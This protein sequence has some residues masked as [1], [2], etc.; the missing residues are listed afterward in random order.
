MEAAR[1]LGARLYLRLQIGVRVLERLPHGVELLRQ[2]AEL[3]VGIG[4]DRLFEVPAGDALRAAA[5]L[6]DRP[7]DAAHGEEHQRAGQQASRRKQ[8]QQQPPVAADRTHDLVPL[9]LRH[10]PPAGA[11]DRREAGDHVR[12][13]RVVADQRV[14]LA[15]DHPRHRRQRGQVGTDAEEVTVVDDPAPPVDQVGGAAAAGPQLQHLREQRPQQ[16]VAERERPA[17]HALEHAAEVEDGHRD[18]DRIVAGGGVVEHVGEGGPQGLLHLSEE[19]RRFVR[20]ACPAPFRDG[21]ARRHHHALPVV[22]Q[23]PAVEH[24]QSLARRLQRRGHAVPVPGAHGVA[25]R[26]VLEY[27]RLPLE[28][29]PETRRRDPRQLS[30]PLR[31]DVAGHLVVGVDADHRHY[32]QHERDGEQRGE[33][34]LGPQALEQR[35]HACR[36]SYGWATPRGLRALAASSRAALMRSYAS[37]VTQLR[38][39][40]SKV[41]R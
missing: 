1:L 3:A 20:V 17:Q 11:G 18:L 8:P 23:D 35:E 31:D 9:L 32:R 15:L 33:H 41:R 6:A 13:R 25:G 10:H 30:V 28:S 22:E 2:L 37:G 36:A 39:R 34:A 38:Q 40:S 14:G 12:P 16:R 26:E 19:G 4:V 7:Q 29:L 5:Q 21:R 27:P 24:E